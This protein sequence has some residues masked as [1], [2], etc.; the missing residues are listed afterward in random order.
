[1]RHIRQAELDQKR[2]EAGSAAAKRDGRTRHHLM[3]RSFARAKRY[4]YDRAR[5]RGRW[6]MEIQEL[7]VCTAQNLHV[8]V[9]K[10]PLPRAES[11]AQALCAARAL[12]SLV[13][14][15]AVWLWPIRSTSSRIPSL[16]P[17]RVPT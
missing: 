4:C 1:M 15:L 5:W 10:R 2:A 17:T 3:E 12:S 11:S 16:L 8:L 7:L 13:F 14:D 9:H 6:R